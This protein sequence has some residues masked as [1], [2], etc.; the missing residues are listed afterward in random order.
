[1]KV[2][3]KIK[4]LREIH[5]I[6]LEDMAS[7]LHLS[8]SGYAKIEKGER[9]LDLIKLEKIAVIFDM[10]VSD[11]ID[12]N[13]ICLITENSHHY[14]NNNNYNDQELRFQV[15]KLTIQL[16]HYQEILKQKDKEIEMLN[17]LIT[18]METGKGNI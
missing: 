4:Q 1:M 3:E 7:K 13:M 17:K 2:N 12:K 18:V 11:L 5:D 15:E 16:E 6:S 9:G 10:T 8:K 14:N